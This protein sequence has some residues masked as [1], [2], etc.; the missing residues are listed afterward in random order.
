MC[1]CVECV[2][3]PNLDHEAKS[4]LPASSTSDEAMVTRM[5]NQA[6]PQH[7]HQP[8]NDKNKA[9]AAHT[10]AS[11]TA[12]T[13]KLTW[14]PV[15]AESMKSFFKGI[16]KKQPSQETVDY[17][18][19]AA[20]GT[21]PTLEF[22]LPVPPVPQI[23]PS[24]IE[25][26]H[27]KQVEEFFEEQDA[28][29]RELKNLST[30]DLLKRGQAVRDHPFFWH[31]MNNVVQVQPEDMPYVEVFCTV[32]N[33]MPEEVCEFELWLK[34]QGFGLQQQA[35]ALAEH[36]P[37]ATAAGHPPSAAPV[38]APAAAE[39]QA[40]AA[41][42]VTG[43]TKAEVGPVVQPPAAA[44]VTGPTVP[45]AAAVA[46]QVHPPDGEHPPAAAPVSAMTGSTVEHPPAA[47]VTQH[48]PAAPA[49][50]PAAAVVGG[51]TTPAAAPVT[52]PTAP[53]VA[54]SAAPMIGSFEA[55]IVAPA[56]PQTV[57]SVTSAAAS[58][59]PSPIGS[60]PS[61]SR[62]W[63]DN[64]LG[65]SQ[66]YPQTV[67]TPV[68]T[69][70]DS[71]ATSPE[72][73]IQMKPITP[74]GMRA[75]WNTLRRKSTDEL[76][77]QQA[78]PATRVLQLAAPAAPPSSAPP[79]AAAMAT[80]AVP[81]SAA[82]EAASGSAGTTQAVPTPAAAE[83]ASGPTGPTH[84]VPTPAAAEAT[85]GSAGPTEAV[86]TPAAAEAASGSAGP[87]EAVPTPAAAEA[88]SGSAGPTQ[89][90]TTPAA[91]NAASGSAA[92]AANATPEAAAAPAAP[93][94]AAET[95]NKTEEDIK[96]ARAAYMRFYRNVRSKK[97]PE[98]VTKHLGCEI[99]V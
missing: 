85:S 25:E 47:P 79:T 49:T 91:A 4:S 82:A 99:G 27:D 55:T 84:A 70:L 30:E 14:Q 97:A 67:T 88:A 78:S 41:T 65:D 45:T 98:A 9:P 22:A 12:D 92:A 72:E 83:A 50:A 53:A 31:W 10:P 40:P 32:L 24:E 94:A 16:P 23:L 80:Q 18:P 11:A 74:D 6:T 52:E 42:P 8:S 33:T 89:A 90:V 44:P 13:D 29:L 62:V 59:A 37:P 96:E 48:P 28:I 75:F 5:R 43:Q 3:T 69:T 81:T 58:A 36:Q 66:L 86:P 19:A 34:T 17:M 61:G 26:C 2:F 1:V 93:T 21:L 38:T 64:Q 51:S 35:E 20:E 68:R 39:V 7:A 63:V 73:S 77:I 57:G 60:L 95:A 56:T 54:T 71:P 87:T 46:T 15:T 76:S